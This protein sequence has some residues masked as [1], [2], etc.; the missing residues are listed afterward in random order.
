MVNHFIANLLLSVP[1]K[2]R[3]SGSTFYEVRPIAKTWCLTFWGDHPGRRR[4][5]CW[6]SRELKSLRL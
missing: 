5:L 4:I 6:A 1:V 3:W 2:A